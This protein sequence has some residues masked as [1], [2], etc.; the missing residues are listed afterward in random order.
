[1]KVDFSCRPVGVL[2]DNNILSIFYY[3]FLLN[4]RIWWSSLLWIKRN[5]KQTLSWKKILDKS[6][7]FKHLPIIFFNYFKAFRLLK[8]FLIFF[9]QTSTFFFERTFWVLKALLS[10]S[11]MPLEFVWDCVWEIK[12]LNKK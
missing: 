2:I 6:F 11:N 5:P 3:K 12:L 4:W 9:Y 8:A 7:I 10:L 1:M